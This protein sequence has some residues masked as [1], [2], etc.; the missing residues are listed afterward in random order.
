[1][2]A[3]DSGGLF[4]F[5][6]ALGAY[7]PMAISGF[8]ETST[9]RL[10][11]PES[12]IDSS[13]SGGPASITGNDLSDFKMFFSSSE[14]RDIGAI[15]LIPLPFGDGKT[16]LILS[17]ERAGSERD[18][19]VPGGWPDI[20]TSVSGKLRAYASRFMHASGAEP[21]SASFEDAKASFNGALST[22]H[23]RSLKTSF[24]VIPLSQA[25]EAIKEKT[26]RADGYR[27]FAEACAALTR[28]F[29]IHGS[30][31]GLPRFRVG[32]LLASQ[33]APDPGLILHQISKGLGRHFSSLGDFSLKTE[34]TLDP[35]SRDFK[36]EELFKSEREGQ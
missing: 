21:S 3:I 31:V 6:D 17:V 11:L 34:Q 29:P 19:A 24:I 12:L 15:R 2:L 28:M 7:A 36:L 23:G 20:E 16:A 14:F 18:A 22:A 1:M 8:D 27:L 9:H 35:S 25:I 5:D 32:I 10:R 4:F 30:V 26:P 13:C 33:V